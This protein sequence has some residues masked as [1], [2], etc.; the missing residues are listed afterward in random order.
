MLIDG[1]VLDSSRGPCLVCLVALVQ[2]IPDI[3]KCG[4]GNVPV[5]NQYRDDHAGNVEDTEPYNDGNH[6]EWVVLRAGPG[7][8]FMLGHTYTPGK[9]DRSYGNGHVS[10]SGATA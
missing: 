7:A 10:R 5:R 2:E 4:Y 1:P 9:S 6:K 8:G 3:S